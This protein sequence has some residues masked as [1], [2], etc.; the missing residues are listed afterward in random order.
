VRRKRDIADLLGKAEDS[1]RAARVLLSEDLPDFAV[2]RGYYAMFYAVE[3]LLLTRGLSFSKHGG[4]AG[5]FGKEFI[6]SGELPRELHR[7]FRD[8]FRLRQAG[9]YSAGSVVTKSEAKRV[10]SQAAEFIKAI[11]RHIQEQEHSDGPA[12]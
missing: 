5:A 11:R 4:V 9:D 6:K 8:A 10:I 3:A 12:V 2:S 1:L 7:Y